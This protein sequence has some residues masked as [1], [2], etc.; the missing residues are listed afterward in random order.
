MY[1]LYSPQLMVLGIFVFSAG[2]TLCILII[3]FHNMGELKELS[4]RI[5]KFF[6]K[7]R[8]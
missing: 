5:K 1:S 3:T 4:R 7:V 8:H 2:F 6:N